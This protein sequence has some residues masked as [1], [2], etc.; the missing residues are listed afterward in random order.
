MNY[1]SKKKWRCFNN[2]RIEYICD[3]S[4]K[5]RSFKLEM[6]AV[7]DATIVRVRICDDVGLSLDPLGFPTEVT[8]VL[9][10]FVRS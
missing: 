6:N 7:T 5:T 10:L 9:C 2:I 4:W 1:P 8:N 3:F